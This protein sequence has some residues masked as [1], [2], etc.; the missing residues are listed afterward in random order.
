MTFAPDDLRNAMNDLARST[1]PLEPGLVLRSAKRRRARRRLAVTAAAAALVAVAGGITALRPSGNGPIVAG[2]SR[3]IQDL[4]DSLHGLNSGNYAFSR[5][6]AYLI[7]DIVRAQVDVADGYAV[8]YG[9]KMSL[10]QV[11]DTTYLKPPGEGTYAGPRALDQIKNAGLPQAEVD[12]YAASIAQLDG[13]RWLRVDQQRLAQAA[14]VDEQSSL[15][16]TAPTPTADKPD[17]T[18]A[19][20]L[21]SAVMTAERSGDTITG[22]LDATKV[23]SELRLVIDDPASYY[24]PPATSMRYQA[25][26]DGQGRL[27]SF[28][29]HLPA[30]LASQAADSQPEPPLAITVTRYGDVEAPQAPP[31]AESITELTYELLA[32]DND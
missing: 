25:T 32:R 18:G 23:N 28:T 3:A 13:T 16:Y 2:D 12:R 24:G 15:D 7:T 31:G 9:N 8:E 20:A 17:I 11:G 30:T 4:D 29:L 19:G 21:V 6:G 1:D 26:L 10:L 14:E 22:T 5:T 27:T